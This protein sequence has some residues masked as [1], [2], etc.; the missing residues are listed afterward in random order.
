[1]AK[2]TL[3]KHTVLTVP[4]AFVRYFCCMRHEA[5]DRPHHFVVPNVFICT[6]L[7]Y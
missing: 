6:V 1:L 4:V 5:F 3:Y 7:L 2:L